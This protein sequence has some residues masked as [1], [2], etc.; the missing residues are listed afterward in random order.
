MVDTLSG[1]MGIL[2]LGQLRSAQGN[3]AQALQILLVVSATAAA[4]VPFVKNPAKKSVTI[5]TT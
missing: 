4:C 5:E 2:V 3:Y 1:V